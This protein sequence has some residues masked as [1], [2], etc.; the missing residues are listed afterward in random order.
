MNLTNLQL[1]EQRIRTKEHFIALM[2]DEAAQVTTSFVNP[3]SVRV[4][5]ERA[6]LIRQIDHF[7]IDG[8]LYVKL[9]NL[10]SRSK[11]N[12][13]S[14]DFSS[15]AT[16]FFRHCQTQ[17]SKVALVGAKAEEIDAAIKNIRLRYPQLDIAYWRHGY[18]SDEQQRQ[19]CFAAINASGAKALICGMGTPH[20]EQ[21]IIAAR[22]ACPAVRFFSTCGGFLTQTS[23]D[24]DYWHPTMNRLGLRWLQRAVQHSHVRDRILRDYPLFI[25]H[26]VKYGLKRKNQDTSA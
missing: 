22:Q 18:F 5:A 8:G 14:F 24:I 11:T 9:F 6:D 21:F 26:Y 15:V 19:Q 13:C 2:Q 12:R 1:L 17:Q 7:Y 23:L 3:F 4:L 10:F 25:W 20:Q 16:D